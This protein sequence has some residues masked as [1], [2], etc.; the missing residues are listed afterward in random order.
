MGCL[1]FVNFLICFSLKSQSDRVRVVC[2]VSFVYFLVV[3]FSLILFILSVLFY[4]CVCV[5]ACVC[6]CVCVSVCPCAR[7]CEITLCGG[8]GGE[9][10]PEAGNFIL[11]I[12]PFCCVCVFVCLNV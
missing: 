1:L 9:R 4:V 8:V 11:T 2:L 5:C 6:V 7:A 10:L 12:S 3:C